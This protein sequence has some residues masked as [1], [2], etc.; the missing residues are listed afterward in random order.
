MNRDQDVIM[1]RD[2]YGI[3]SEGTMTPSTFRVAGIRPWADEG[4]A[5]VPEGVRTFFEGQEVTMD[6]LRALV[7]SFGAELDSAVQGGGREQ[8]TIR[9]QGRRYDL[10][11]ERLS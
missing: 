9:W 8:A 3:A 6:D 7:A 11:L 4:A 1:N 2:E 10:D 5:A